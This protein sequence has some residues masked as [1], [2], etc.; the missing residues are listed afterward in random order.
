[1]SG[2]LGSVARGSRWLS[3]AGTVM[4]RWC[5]GRIPRGAPGQA[6]FST[7]A[8]TTNAPTSY[9]AGHGCS[10]SSTSPPL[11]GIGWIPSLWRPARSRCG[12]RKLSRA[13][14]SPRKDQR[15]VGE[16]L[17]QETILRDCPRMTEDDSFTFGCHGSL[18]CFTRCCRDVAIVLTPYDVL[19]LK[20]ALRIES[21]ELLDRYTLSPFNKE[22]K[23]PAVIL[24]M[25]P[26][27]KRCP[28]VTDQGCSVYAN[29]PWPAGCTRWASPSQESFAR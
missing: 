1:V 11:T 20:R 9:A 15:H 6:R 4:D 24:R 13:A 19:R 3:T 26:E 18:D 29:R 10:S 23:I 22:Q 17:T 28:F 14:L 27:T 5:T 8:S 16:A 21:S 25:D 7:S 2:D 12:R